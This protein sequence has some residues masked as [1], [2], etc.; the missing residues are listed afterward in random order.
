MKINQIRPLEAKFTE[1]LE[2]IAL[3]PKMLYYIG[4]LPENV[5]K[6]IGIVG[7]RRCTAYG[8][9]VAYEAAYEC[10]K[11]GAIVVSG[12]AYGIDSIAARG[13]LDAGGKT[14]AI[15]GTPIDQ[16]YPEEHLGLAR[17]IVEKGGA[18]LSEYGPRSAKIMAEMGLVEAEVP[19]GPDEIRKNGVRMANC[20]TTFLYRN[21]LIAALSEVVLITE[22]TEKSGSLNTASHALEQSREL[23]A[24][25]GDITR[26]TSVGCNRLIAQGAHPYLGPQGVLEMLF[27][28]RR[29]WGRKKMPIFSGSPTE[30][31]IV[32]EIVSGNIDGEEIIRKLGISA[33][34]FTQAITML[35]IRDLVRPLGMNKWTIKS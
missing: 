33:P 19:L 18:I 23:F 6:T 29:S 11:A 21:R 31:A 22:A 28:E 3:K 26:R 9:K 34:E 15:L 17:E 14:I 35:E 20:R 32:A 5:V 30:K 27:P 13:A 1:V 25:P 2:T 10:A 8:E 4:K 24:V 12:L 7:A 16:I